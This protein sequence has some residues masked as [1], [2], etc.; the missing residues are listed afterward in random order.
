MSFMYFT[1]VYLAHRL[2]SYI[3]CIPILVMHIYFSGI[4]MDV[5]SEI[6]K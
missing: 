1:P 4:Y 2:L 5:M 6:M 3:V